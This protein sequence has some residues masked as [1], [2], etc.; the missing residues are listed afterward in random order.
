V[1]PSDEL[2]PQAR[3]DG[4]LSQG[5]TPVRYALELDI[6]PRKATFRGTTTIVIKVERSS[7]YVVL[8]ARDLSIRSVAADVG[9]KV[10]LGTSSQRASN[11]REELLLHFPQDLPVGMASLRISY[12]AAFNEDDRPRGLFRRK[13]TSG[14][15]A[16]TDFEPSAARRMFPC[17][18]EPDF[19]SPFDA[20]V[21]VPSGMDVFSNM[22]V[23]ARTPTEDGVRFH[24]AT[25]PP[26]P[27]YL[28]ALAVGEF[29]VDVG[30][31]T[32]IP[33]RLIRP[34]GTLG[35]TALQL[36]AAA[37]VMGDLSNLLDTPYPFPK[38]DLI[39]I[40]QFANHAMEN[41]G[42]ISFDER[43]LL[44]EKGEG[45]VFWKRN[46]VS[47]IAHELAHQWTGDL[48]TLR[49][50]DDIWLNE[51]FATFLEARAIDRWRPSFR[52][53]F[54]Q[55]AWIQDRM[56]RDAE[57][58][59]P[60]REQVVTVEDAERVVR[61]GVQYDKGASFLIMLERFVGEDTF[62][63]S[64][65]AY[66]RTYAWKGATTD[67]F[68]RVLAS[69]SKHDVAPFARAFLEQSGIPVVEVEEKCGGGHLES[70][71]I[72]Q[73]SFGL[74]DPHQGQEKRTWNIPFCALVQGMNRTICRE[75]ES[76]TTA[77]TLDDPGSRCP[78][79]VDPNPR[80]AGYYRY[81]VT[82][83]QL[84][85]AHS[86]AVGLTPEAKL[87]LLFNASG[88]V[89][90][91]RLAPAAVLEFLPLLDRESDPMV[92][93]AIEKFLYFVRWNFIGEE[94]EV[95]F[96]TYVAAR[97]A[98]HRSALGVSTN[99]SPPLRHQDF[100]D[101]N[102][103]LVKR[104]T[105]SSLALV[106]S[107]SALSLA[108]RMTLSWLGDPASSPDVD[109][110]DI[111]LWY[112]GEKIDSSLFERLV[113]EVE[114]PTVLSNRA[115]ALSSLADTQDPVL[116]RQAL[117]LTLRLDLE[118]HQ[119]RDLFWNAAVEPKRRRVVYDWIASEWPRIRSKWPGG[120]V[121]PVVNVLA[122]A[123]EDEQRTRLQELFGGLPDL[124]SSWV[125]GLIGDAI[126]RRNLR[127]YGEPSTT[128]YLRSL[129]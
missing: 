68:V 95:D 88:S 31:A 28:F 44:P 14:W 118:L 76:D 51:G 101:D 129:R 39:A 57:S 102:A 19:K 65:R 22:P 6:D 110:G 99:A 84:R 128:R 20:T 13:N 41:A 46:V 94:T 72:R 35:K 125:D 27:T 23:A 91:R 61:R 108:R 32:P 73:S 54:R 40:P 85:L 127:S 53:Q 69:V 71:T 43:I 120:K 98:R 122:L 113:A 26:L 93:R 74:D 47:T 107:E 119:V 38:L 37:G 5:A 92:L 103:V 109:L 82:E 49:W 126:R 97:M 66:L 115:W 45:S 112:V 81:D 116:L 80:L 100:L 2:E 12:D 16:F 105:F 86:V 124:S 104:S 10:I 33:V 25:T 48:V 42:L 79:W 11:N 29:D 111:A 90:R 62:R 60:V 36:E 67:D 50:W 106:G 117:D 4:R 15:Y 18:D 59:K 17:F 8:H 96:R 21:T 64:I 87:G 1:L 77:L 123:C 24:F 34:H 55:L 63:E 9:G 30:P 75:V 3:T 56:E 7:S 58:I 70:I 52:A 121:W 89:E 83:E 114:H 78:G